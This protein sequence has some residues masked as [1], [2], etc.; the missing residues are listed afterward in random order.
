M[1]TT[2]LFFSACLH[3]EL[4]A[5]EM[6]LWHSIVAVSIRVINVVA[7]CVCGPGLGLGGPASV[8]GVSTQKNVPDVHDHEEDKSVGRSSTNKYPHSTARLLG[9]SRTRV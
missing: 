7:R 8:D 1:I 6:L 3:T 9:D 2:V 5:I 4:S